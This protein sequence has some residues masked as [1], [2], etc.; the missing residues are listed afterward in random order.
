MTVMY[1]LDNITLRPISQINLIQRFHSAISNT[2]V[3]SS[4]LLYVLKTWLDIA[5]FSQEKFKL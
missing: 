3:F 2:V 4:S 1:N 5:L